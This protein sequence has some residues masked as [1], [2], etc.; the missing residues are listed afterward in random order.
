M[1]LALLSLDV[2]TV[3]YR[4]KKLHPSGEVRNDPLHLQICS[5]HH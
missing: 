1:C 3:A 5:L 2:S 4:A